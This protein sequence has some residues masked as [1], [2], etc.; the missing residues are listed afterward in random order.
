MATVAHKISDT[1]CDV[2]IRTGTFSWCTLK[3]TE[4]ARVLFSRESWFHLSDMQTLRITATD[5][6]SIPN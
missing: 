3:K 1:D 5:P 2:V 4:S 6:Q